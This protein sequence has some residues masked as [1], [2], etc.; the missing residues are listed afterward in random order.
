MPDSEG[1]APAW[2]GAT[3]ALVTTR[4]AATEATCPSTPAPATSQGTGGRASAIG[5]VWTGC[6]DDMRSVLQLGLRYRNMV[7]PSKIGTL[8]HKTFNNGRVGWLEKINENE[9]EHVQLDNK[10]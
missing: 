2:P 10:H 5:D 9:N 1:P 3:P 6:G 7:T 8:V 4:G